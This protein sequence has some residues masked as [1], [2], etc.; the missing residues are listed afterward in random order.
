MQYVRKWRAPWK[1]G[2]FQWVQG[3][4]S[5]SRQL[6][7]QCLGF[8]QVLRRKALGEPAVNGR[9]ELVGFTRTCLVAHQPRTTGRG[10]QLPGF[11]LLRSRPVERGDIG[12][13]GPCRIAL[14]R[15]KPA[16]DAE[17]FGI[18]MALLPTRPLDLRDRLVDQDK[19]SGEIAK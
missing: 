16:L 12:A 6:I 19:C 17:R 14:Q 2:F 5:G 15:K 4:P 8:L 9:E 11:R 18:I 13:L 1:G 10:A 7:E 3:P